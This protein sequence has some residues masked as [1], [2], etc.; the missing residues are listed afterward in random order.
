MGADVD[1]R[2]A[3]LLVFIQE[4]TPGRNGAAADGMCFGIIDL[5][6]LA[7]LTGLLQILRVG[8]VPV[9]IADGQHF[10]RAA[11]G[12]QHFLSLFGVN[13]HGLFAHDMLTSLQSVHC[14]KAVFPVGSADMNHL[15]GFI[16]QQLFVIRVILGPG[17]TEFLGG[18]FGAL[19]NNIAEGHH[20]NVFHFLEG[21]HVLAVGNSAA[22]DNAQ[23][24]DSFH[25]N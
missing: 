12:I 23:L 15:D 22:A 7:G 4:H 20:L 5:A 17:Y 19:F 2:T 8:T 1:Q 11:G 9:L 18:F 16:L 21:G 13:R 3:A 10:S 14:D 25:R 6:Q 24:Y